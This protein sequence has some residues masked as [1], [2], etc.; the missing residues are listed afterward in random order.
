MN[1]SM[2]TNI[3]FLEH[4]IHSVILQKLRHEFKKSLCEM[5]AGSQSAE[6]E[7]LEGDSTE[8][9]SASSH[10]SFIHINNI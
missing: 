6:K 10:E 8:P 4:N 2:H 5:A 9:H 1:L 7:P 3:L